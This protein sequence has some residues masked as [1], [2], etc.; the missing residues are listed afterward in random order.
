MKRNRLSV[1]A[2]CAVVLGLMGGAAWAAEEKA[3]VEIPFDFTVLSGTLK[4]GAYVVVTDGPK[5]NRVVLRSAAT[6]RVIPLTVTTRLA[7]LGGKD[8]LLVFDTVGSSRYLSEI[9]IPGI[10]GYALRGSALEHRHE[11]VPGTK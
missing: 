6:G 1:L 8:P 4:A 11:T 3:H 5:D 9:H 2:A 7:D 10:D